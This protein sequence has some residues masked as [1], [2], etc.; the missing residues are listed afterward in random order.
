MSRHARVGLATRRG[1]CDMSERVMTIL[2]GPSRKL[3]DRRAHEVFEEQARER[4]DAIATMHGSRQLTY[5]EV[6][7]RANRVARALL[8][9]GLTREGVVGVVTERNLDWMTAVLAI[10]KAGGTYLPIE[11]HFPPER[12]A[13]T[14]SRSGC[15]LVLTERASTAMLDRAL[16]SLSGTQTL[17]IDAAY[18]EGH[19]DG[20]LGIDVAPDQLAYIYFTSGSTGEPKGAMCEHL[21]LLNHLFAKIEDLEIRAGTVV[22]QTAP[23]CFDIS[24]WQLLS[25]LLVGGQTLLVEQETIL[26]A[27][28]FIDKIVEGRVAVVQV[29]PSYLEVLVS[30]L[31]R[32]P[33]ELPDLRCV[34]ATGE[35]LKKEL[36]QRWF[37]AQP[38]I[39]LVNAYG[40]TETSDDTNHEIMD[41]VPRRKCVPL[42]HAINNVF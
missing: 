21:G 34:S 3:P 28:R 24:L 8:A 19:A 39:K 9:R 42:G 14:L 7:A 30:Y 29:V 10:F 38:G 13:K 36:T 2:A 23:Q 37:A 18:E 12:I 11:P 20:D 35:A 40:L 31:A 41:S 26:D 22:A 4:P 17:F 27:K 32:R 5:G 1:R 25:A 6:N 16:Q 33:R 15:R